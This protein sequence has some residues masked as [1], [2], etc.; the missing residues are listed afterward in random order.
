M[1]LSAFPLREIDIRGREE[2]LA[3]RIVTSAK[4]LPEAPLTETATETD[5]PGLTAQPV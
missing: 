5:M 3:V 4:D 1:D 2:K